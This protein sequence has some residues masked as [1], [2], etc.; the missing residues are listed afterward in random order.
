MAQSQYLRK[1][2]LLHRLTMT[3]TIP[4]PDQFS[5]EL[6]DSLMSFPLALRNLQIRKRGFKGRLFRAARIDSE[7]DL[8]RAF[9]HME[10]PH[11]F[12]IHTILAAFHT[13]IA[14]SS[15][16]PTLPPLRSLHLQAC[17]SVKREMDI[18]MYNHKSSERFPGLPFLYGDH[19]H[20]AST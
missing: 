6:E 9:P 20:T 15:A 8:P 3:E 12:K 2:L 5:L 14:F 7:Y 18:L 10:D 19:I 1:N 11:L 13:V 17:R 4:D 16:E